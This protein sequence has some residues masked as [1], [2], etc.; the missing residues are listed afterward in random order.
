MRN[1]EINNVYVIRNNVR[2]QEQACVSTT[3]WGAI[4]S[5][6]LVRVGRYG[7]FLPVGL[8]NNQA[9]IASIGQSSRVYISESHTDGNYTVKYYSNAASA[10]R[11]NAAEQNYTLA[12]SPQYLSHPITRQPFV[13]R[14]HA[15]SDDGD[16]FIGVSGQNIIR[17]N[18]YANQAN[19]CSSASLGDKDAIFTPDISNHG[20]YA[21][22]AGANFWK[23]EVMDLDYTSFDLTQQWSDTLPCA[24]RIFTDYEIGGSYPSNPQFSSDGASIAYNI[25]NQNGTVDE[26]A[27]WSSMGNIPI[28][29]SQGVNYLGLGDSFSSGEGDHNNYLPGT[30]GTVEYSNEKCHISTNS[31]PARLGRALE[32]DNFSVACSGA[33]IKDTI[34]KGT[35]KY[36]GNFSQLPDKVS[37]ETYYTWRLN[38]LE[39]KTPG[40]IPQIDFVGTYLP[41]AVTLSIGGNDVQFG[42]MLMKCLVNENDC[43]TIDDRSKANALISQ[44]Y[45]QLREAYSTMARKSPGT[46]FFVVGYPLLFSEHSDRCGWNVHLSGGERRFINESTRYLNDVIAAAAYSTRVHYV[47][48]ENIFGESALCGSNNTKAMNGL[49]S[50]GEYGYW[51]LHFGQES[52]HPTAYGHQL[53]AESI[54]RQYGKLTSYRDPLCPIIYISG[55]CQPYS[56]STQ[57]TPPSYFRTGSTSTT[58]LYG[59]SPL[60]RKIPRYTTNNSY[61]IWLDNELFAPSSLNYLRVYSKPRDLGVFQANEEGKLS[62]SFNLPNDLESGYHTLVLDGTS[63][64]GQPIRYEQVIYVDN[65]LRPLPDNACG[66]LIRVSGVDQDN[67]NVDDACDGIIESDNPQTIYSPYDRTQ[68]SEQSLTPDDTRS[69]PP[70]Q[71]PHSSSPRN[72]TSIYTQSAGGSRYVTIDDMLQAERQHSPISSNQSSPVVPGSNFNTNTTSPVSDSPYSSRNASNITTDHHHDKSFLNIKVISLFIIVTII[73]LAIIYRLRTTKSA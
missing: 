16:W 4:T 39:S 73:G 26:W 24:N 50:G 7:N 58:R 65:P 22:L 63:P 30:D 5:D 31:Y 14:S 47:D 56:R 60:T 46:E 29:G 1:C 6:G 36:L 64:D 53:I 9:I 70:Q 35:D 41:R 44:Q 48:I 40:R 59:T 25:V 19:Q 34:Y 11:Y 68:Y 15:F 10:L 69:T 18:L 17:I 67:D 23:L 51:L 49:A 42:D 72:N 13:F 12:G 62:G 28:P 3:A 54:T 33:K 66:G 27:I 38:T 45:N 57:P 37:T 8:A 2:R 20:A 52:F 43:G 61:D 21:V 32:G 55:S 71:A